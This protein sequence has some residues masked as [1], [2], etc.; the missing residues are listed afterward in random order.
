MAKRDSGRNVEFFDLPFTPLPET[1]PTAV[2]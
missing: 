1:E 2:A